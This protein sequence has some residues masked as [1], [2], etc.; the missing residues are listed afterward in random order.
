MRLPIIPFLIAATLLTGVWYLFNA[1]HSDRKTPDAP[2]LSRLADIEGSE[3]EVAIAPDGNRYAIISGGHLW[4]LNT[5]TRE[6]H[7]MTRTSERESF[8]AWTPDGK[9]ISFTRGSDTFGI[10]PV[11][12]SER[13]L[14]PNA[15]S[16][17]WSSTNRSIFVRD[18]ALWITNAGG[19]GEKKLVEAD[20]IPDVTI[21]NARFS[22]DSLQIAY[23]KTQLN[24]R[25]EVWVVDVAGGMSRP[26]VSD[27]LAEN[28]MDVA[29]INDGLELAF[30]TDR[31][32][33]YSVWYVDFVR[34][35]INPLT[36]PLNIVPLER[37]GM[38][39]FK[40]RLVVPRHFVDSNITLSDGSA[41]ASSD[42]IE[43]EPA[44]SPDGSLIAYT[45]AAE[46]KMEIWTA[47]LHGEKP[48]FRAVGHQ[49]RFSA[50]G[51][52]IV[53][54][55]ADLVGNADIW[56]MD[57]RNGSVERVTDADEID[58][59]ADWSADG[60]SI[61]F[62]SARGG[63]ISIWTI[64]VSGGK[65]LRINDGGYGPRYSSDSKSILFWNRQAL[66][67]SQA[68]GSNARE[69]MRNLPE[70]RIGLWTPKGPA[71]VLNGEVQSPSEKLLGIAGHL[72]W[73]AFD[74]LK[75][76]RL[77]IAPIDIHETSLWA[78]D[79]TYKEN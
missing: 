12:N 27:R 15:T 21:R 14:Q 66:W 51:Y 18:R 56:K 1:S 48:L 35:T 68:D 77:V 2:R 72:I 8:P 31:A 3:T 11:T 71:V 65:R 23:I 25:G 55:H 32:G 19:L 59:A 44:A 41:V 47:G 63:A 78:V 60:R 16:M 76:G 5:S 69:I 38:A 40:D 73:P 26:L 53:Y 43:M 46:N 17:S 6:R 45:V 75:D 7:Q 74:V 24:L 39:V 52:Q 4:I 54:T 64:P 29:W 9:T 13:T 30:L 79:L 61:A 70:P 58:T 50:N 36:Q 37:I 42:K 20:S 33:S 10:D 22:P 62:S 28:P 67:V 57:I 49:P 34:S